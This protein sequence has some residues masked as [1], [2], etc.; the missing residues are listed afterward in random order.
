MAYC[1][2]HLGARGRQG[3]SS[4]T[5]MPALS[6]CVCPACS[7]RKGG[8]LRRSAAAAMPSL[9]VIASRCACIAA[10]DQQYHELMRQSAY[11]WQFQCTWFH[12]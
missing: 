5:F 4:R 11:A 6:P 8:K 9:L 12:E 10:R 2:Q 7:W 3:L 1:R